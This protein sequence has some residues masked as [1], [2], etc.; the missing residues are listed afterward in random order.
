MRVAGTGCPGRSLHPCKYPNAT[1]T[2][3]WGTGSGWP[4]LSRGTGPDDRSYLVGVSR[5]KAWGTSG[6]FSTPSEGMWY[7]G[8]AMKG[9]E[10]AR[11][12]RGS[13]TVAPLPVI[14]IW[15]KNSWGDQK[16]FDVMVVFARHY[17]SKLRGEGSINTQIQGFLN[18]HTYKVQQ[19]W[20][21]YKS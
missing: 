17:R 15:S 11:Q 20:N 16:A 10:K 1:W 3:S 14:F 8:S 5:G 21:G 9:K 12:N 6:K 13:R 7:T 2:Q 19:T 18:I 4:C